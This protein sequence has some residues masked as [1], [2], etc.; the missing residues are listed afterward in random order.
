HGRG[1]RLAHTV[2][3]QD[4]ARAYRDQVAVDRL[5]RALLVQEVEAALPGAPVEWRMAVLGR[6]AAGGIDQHRLAG[7]EP[8]AVARAAD[9]AHLGAIAALTVRKLEPGMDKRRGL[10]GAGRPDHD[11]P[12]QLI[13]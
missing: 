2:V 5:A 6:V 12:R 1:M 4:V 11:V 13:Q 8:V 7:E 9:A 10:A 3:G